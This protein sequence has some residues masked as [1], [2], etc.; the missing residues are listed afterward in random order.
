MLFSPIFA[1]FALMSSTNIAHWM[2]RI[3]NYNSTIIYITC[4]L[5]AEVVTK[6]VV[7]THILTV[8][9]TPYKSKKF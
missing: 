6:I 7:L 3:Q 1:F 5:I 9:P 4:Y 8:F 2:T